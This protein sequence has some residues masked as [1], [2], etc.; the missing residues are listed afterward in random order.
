[1]FPYSLSVPPACFQRTQDPGLA[2]GTRR[3]TLTFNC[4]TGPFP[5]PF[6]LA[7]EPDHRHRVALD[8]LLPPAAFPD[9][10]PNGLQV[11]GRPRR[12]LVTGVSAQ[13]E[14]IEKAA[15]M[16]AQLVL[17]HHGVCDFHPTG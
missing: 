8:E 12:A 11:P 3:E 17:V 13:R 16:H 6:A 2:P 1:M 15:R 5:T 14:L 4:Q 9:L 7:D 10:G